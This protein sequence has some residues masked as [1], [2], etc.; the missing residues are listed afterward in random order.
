MLPMAGFKGSHATRRF[1][2]AV[3]R[4]DRCKRYGD[5]NAVY[6]L[7]INGID[8]VAAVTKAGIGAAVKIP[9]VKK[10]TAG[11]YGGSLGKFKVNRSDLF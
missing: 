8:A 1:D 7:V 10:T 9:E 5:V 3:F 11:N 6:E 2:R 4:R